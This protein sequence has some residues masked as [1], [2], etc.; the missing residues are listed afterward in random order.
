MHVNSYF[1]CAKLRDR[2]PSCSTCLRPL[3]AQVPACLHFFTCP[4][5]LHFFTG[6]MCLHIFRCL[7]CHHFLRAFIF[8]VP[9]FFTCLTVSHCFTCL[10]FFMC[11]DFLR[12]LRAIIFLRVYI[13]FMDMLTHTN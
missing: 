9:S 13:L 12:A 5:C 11:L 1:E 2:V 6:L 8:Y 10:Y 7:S 3:R 4:T